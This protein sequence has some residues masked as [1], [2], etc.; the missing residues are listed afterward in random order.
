[1]TNIFLANLELQWN[2]TSKFHFSHNNLIFK[3]KYMLVPKLN[4]VLVNHEI[5][6]SAAANID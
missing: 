6:D 4:E 1:M 3:N 2:A 5:I